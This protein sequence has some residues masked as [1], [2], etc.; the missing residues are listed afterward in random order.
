MKITSLTK[1][2]S[3][4]L[5]A[6][7][8]VIASSST[9]AEAATVLDF[10]TELGNGDGIPDTYGDNAAG[11]PNIDITWNSPADETSDDGW[12]SYADW[13]GRGEVGQINPTGGVLTVTFTPDAGFGAFVTSFDLDEFTG[14]GNT[15]T[16][17]SLLGTPFSGTWDDY[18]DAQGGNGGRTNISTGMTSADAVFGPLVLELTQV[19]GFG[20]YL[21]MDNLA[22]DQ[23]EVPEPTAIGLALLGLGGL[24]AAG[25]RRE[26]K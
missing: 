15:I 14:G 21:A 23:V 1:K 7:G 2:L 8:A 20:S 19:S 4:A 9:A 5:V 16:D 6:G 12:D 25:M 3:A 18:S 11:T 26:R 13:D 22:F 10:V 24:G 17:W